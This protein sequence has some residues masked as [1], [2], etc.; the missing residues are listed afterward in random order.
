MTDTFTKAADM[1]SSLS[2][3]YL[4]DAA[5]CAREEDP[6][7]YTEWQLRQAIADAMRR[8]GRNKV[9]EVINEEIA[10]VPLT[11]PKIE[12]MEAAE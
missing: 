5:K 7:G 10:A 11:Y 4:I 8:I 6:E 1:A 9:I 2:S 3:A 12:A